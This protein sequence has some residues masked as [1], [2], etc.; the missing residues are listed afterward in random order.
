MTALVLA[1]LALAGVFWLPP[2]W[3]ALVFWAVAAL[4]CYEWANLLHLDRIWQKLIYVSV[5]GLLAAALYL[6]GANYAAV[7]WSGAVIWLAAVIAVLVFPRGTGIYQQRLLM[8]LLGW[9]IFVAAWSGLVVIRAAPQG[10]F[11]LVWLFVLVWGADIGA[12]FSGRTL[13]KR[14]L[15]PAVSPGKSWEGAIGGFVLAAVLC[16]AG[17]VWLEADL[18][19]FLPL[20]AGLIVLSVFGDLFES[21][22]KRSSGVKDS[23]TLLPGHGGV[24]DRIDSL[25]AVLPVFALVW[26]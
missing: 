9:A 4:G 6:D 15:A 12:Y 22:M 20:M 25:L 10:S 7:L 8:G 11:W 13:G 18:R 5:Y 2:A 26:V 14:K 24:L 3:F 23:G 19:L 1:P 16:S 17:A 21:V